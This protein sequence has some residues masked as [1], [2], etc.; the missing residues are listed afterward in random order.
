MNHLPWLLVPF[1]YLVASIS[2]AWLVA[3]WHGINLREHGSGNLGA[4]NV[5]RVLGGR[6]FALVFILDCGKGWAPVAMMI[7][8]ISNATDPH[9]ALLQWGP[10]ST[11]LAAVIGHI[12]PCYHGLRGGKAVATS[13]GVIIALSPIVA[14]IA[15]IAW[16]LAWAI[17]RL[18]GLRASMA[19]GPASVVAAIIA[20]S[21]Q[22]WWLGLAG[23]QRGATLLISLA[24]ALILWRH[25]SNLGD[26][27]GRRQC[28][29]EQHRNG[30]AEERGRGAPAD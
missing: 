12:F 23:P 28:D 13:L 27:L 21:F 15:F 14:F 16:L 26:L 29:T 11:G 7:W 17:G 25:R 18:S 22:W 8:L 19:V 24:G 20:V 3:R 10:M 4:T 2:F 30:G 5:G 9:P 6:W 1:A